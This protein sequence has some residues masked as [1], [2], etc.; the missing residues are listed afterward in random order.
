[1]D[2]QINRLCEDLIAE[3]WG[4]LADFPDEISPA[5]LRVY[6]TF[7]TGYL[8]F[9]RQKEGKAVDWLPERLVIDWK[10]V[11][12]MR[13]FFSDYQHITQSFLSLNRRLDQLRDMDKDRK[14]GLYREL[15]AEII[16]GT[17]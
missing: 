9:L 16:A 8:N 5:V 17:A 13:H 7:I 12:G 15:V 14:P 6:R 1:M 11:D 3:Q 10:L 2:A 4:N